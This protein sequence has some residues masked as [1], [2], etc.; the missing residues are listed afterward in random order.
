MATYP[1]VGIVD[2]GTTKIVCLIG[3]LTEDNKINILGYSEKKSAGVNRGL[4]QNV[5]DAAKVIKEVV[6][7]AET[8]ANHKLEYVYVGIA[9]QNI[10][11][12]NTSH[13]VTTNKHMDL[14]TNED[15][16]R[17]IKEVYNITL[18][19]GES[20]LQVFP[21]EYFV[22]NTKIDNPVGTMGYQLSGN[23]KVVTTKT[24][25]ISLIKTALEQANLKLKHILLEPYASAQATLTEEEKEAGVCLIDMG[26]GTTD[27]IIIKDKIVRHIGVI[28]IAGNA[29][30]KDIQTG[31]TITFDNAEKLKIQH[32]SVLPEIMNEDEIIVVEGIGGRGDKEISKKTLAEIIQA[33]VLE[34]IDTVVY[35]IKNSNLSQNLGAGITITGGGALLNK[36]T[37]LINYRTGYETRIGIPND[38]NII[39]SFN[40][41][42]PK[43][44]TAIGLLKLALEAEKIYNTQKQT[45]IEEEN[46]QQ[47][48]NTNKQQVQSTENNKKNKKSIVWEYIKNLTK[49]FEDNSN[50][51]NI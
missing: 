24:K 43:Y 14:I 33:R 12:Q 27:F 16:N 40:Y 28:P 17:L 13:S 10:T 39:T 2:I 6:Q 41:K 34:L 32:G 48:E 50:D 21:Q 31:F 9:G 47:Q 45:K 11:S 15:V 8:M 51:N 37:D 23:F 46:K 19:A 20:V 1:K 3:Q 38:I 29:I 18:D 30:T 4:V 35:E 44:S 49:I 42:N 22:D 5:L 26:G 7:E 36:I 25:N